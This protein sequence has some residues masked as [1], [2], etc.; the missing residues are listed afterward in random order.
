[1]RGLLLQGLGVLVI[2]AGIALWWLLDLYGCAFNT[3]GCSRV[4]PNPFAGSVI[5]FLAGAVI[6]GGLFYKGRLM[7]R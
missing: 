5:F 6:G 2:A 3:M 4:L 1:M 7:R